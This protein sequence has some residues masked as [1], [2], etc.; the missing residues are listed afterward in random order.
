MHVAVEQADEGAVNL[1]IRE[2]LLPYHHQVLRIVVAARRFAVPRLRA[3]VS[4]I[5]QNPNPDRPVWIHF[6]QLQVASDSFVALSK[7]RGWL[8]ADRAKRIAPQIKVVFTTAYAQNAVVH[9]G[10]LDAGVNLLPKPFTIE[11]LARMC[12]TVLDGVSG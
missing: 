12:R 1:A 2:R 3:T 8:S 9:H 11:R 4:Q 10:L 5:W 7:M 6:T